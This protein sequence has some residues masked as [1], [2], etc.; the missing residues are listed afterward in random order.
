MSACF[1]S[2]FR[3]HFLHSNSLLKLMPPKQ[4]K[5]Y[6]FCIFCLANLVSECGNFARLNERN[7]MRSS[8]FAIFQTG[9]GANP[10]PPPGKGGRASATPVAL[11]RDPISGKGTHIL[12]MGP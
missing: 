1:K 7:R 12:Q 5:T 9:S 11:Q 2:I 4:Y 3:K 8:A 10:Y 6:N